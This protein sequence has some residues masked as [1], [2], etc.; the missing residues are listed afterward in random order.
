MALPSRI[1]DTPT[2]TTLTLRDPDGVLLKSDDGQLLRFV[3][4]RSTGVI[5][6]AM[7]DKRLLEKACLVP[8]TIVNSKQTTALLRKYEDRLPFSKSEVGLVLAHE[9]VFFPSFPYEWCSEAL[10]KAGILTLDFAEES[11]KRGWGLKD[12]TPYNVLYE[13]TRPVFVDWLSLELRAPSDPT[14][15]AFSQFVRCFILPL[16]MDRHGGLPL[17]AGFLSY[18]DGITPEKAYELVPMWRRFTPSFF[19]LVALPVWMNRRKPLRESQSAIYAQSGIPAERARFVLKR[20]YGFLR[21]QLALV[22]ATRARWSQWNH[23]LDTRSP[24][25]KSQWEI[26]RRTLQ[27]WLAKAKPDSVLDIGCNE[28]WFSLLAAE[29]G[30]RVISIDN[31]REMVR[32]TWLRAD[33]QKADVQAL[34]VDICRPSPAIGWRN[35]ESASFLDRSRNKFDLVAALAVVHHLS[36][37]EQ[38]SYDEIFAVIHSMTK[39]HFFVEFV[40][41]EDDSFA[42]AAKG[43]PRERWNEAAFMRALQPYF[44]VVDS[45]PIPDSHRTLYWL[46]KR[47]KS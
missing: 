12:A 47:K 11:L 15:F 4:T 5:E 21:Q 10:V 8:T 6:K 35:Q 23:Y 14:W 32:R 44:N 19:T 29:S 25:E 16:W 20:L 46:Q 33:K 2:G 43:R 7:T 31:D 42:W 34:N 41:P 26:K 27:T 24:Y 36:I 17:Q 28:G 30:A 38:L 39:S 18:R 1:R 22:G 9:S 37:G 40:G 3:S 45:T 13:G